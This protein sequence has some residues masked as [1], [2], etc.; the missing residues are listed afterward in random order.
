MRL[1]PR[2][3]P[4]ILMALALVVACVVVVWG[5]D[6]LLAR[7]QLRASLERSQAE[8]AR[9]DAANRRLLLELRAME[10]DPVVVERTVADELKWARPG[11]R[12][13]QFE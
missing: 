10:R 2:L 9:L 5:G 1:S 13:V 7:Q 8:L 6:G 4:S 3:L 12:I 11:D